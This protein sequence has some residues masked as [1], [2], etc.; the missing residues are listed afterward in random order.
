MVN[1][2]LMSLSASHN[3]NSKKHFRALGK[4]LKPVLKYEF[5]LRGESELW[6]WG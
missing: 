4:G 6:L 2:V 3:L 1:P 5:S